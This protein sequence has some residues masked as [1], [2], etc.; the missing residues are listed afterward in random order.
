MKAVILPVLAFSCSLV[1]T[2]SEHRGDLKNLLRYFNGVT[3]RKEQP[4]ANATNF[5]HERLQAQGITRD[6]YNSA[7]LSAAH[8]GEADLLRLMIDVGADVNYANSAGYSALPL[9]AHEG[10]TECV[11]LLLAAPGVDLNRRNKNDL[12]AL[13]AAQIEEN[14]ECI[15]LL[16]E[17]GAR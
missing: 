13:D 15:G 8:K 9:A 10:H 16:T 1:A 12:T 5:E 4:N 6:K 14:D 11:K 7:L 17:A 3:E 2:G